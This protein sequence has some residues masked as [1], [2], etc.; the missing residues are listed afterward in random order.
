MSQPQP[1]PSLVPVEQ[2]TDRQIREGLY[3]KVGAIEG[4][5]A[6]RGRNCPGVLAAQQNGLSLHISGGGMKALGA[7][8]W[9]VLLAAVV[10]VGG[11]KG[12]ESIEGQHRPAGEREAPK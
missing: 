8:L 4:R 12:C 1:Q 6:E 9:P 10:A 5:C 11:I 2:M 3:E 7:K